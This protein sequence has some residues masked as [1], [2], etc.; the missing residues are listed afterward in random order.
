MAKGRQ[1][2]Q[3]YQDALSRLGRDL[4]R[5]SRRRCELSEESGSLMT[6]DLEG[7]P[8]D[9][10]LSH[11]LFV[12]PWIYAMLEGSAVDPVRLRCLEGS[13]WSEE[14]A[15]RRASMRLLK[16]IDEA[17]ARETLEGVKALYEEE[18]TLEL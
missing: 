2:H 4:A 12:S 8:L 11:V 7:A 17:W 3:D 14:P 16:R 10:E 9:P 6:F 18:A 13:A 15:I 1:R 5:R